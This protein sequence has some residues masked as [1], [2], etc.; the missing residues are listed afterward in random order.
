[1]FDIDQQVVCIRDD[2]NKSFGGEI[3]PKQG[4][5]LTIR[6]I[7]ADFP[8]DYTYEVGLLFYEIVNPLK[9]YFGCTTAKEISFPGSAFRP[10]KKTDISTI[11]ITKVPE[12]VN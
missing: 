7:L 2:W 10:V 12:K 9:V 4:Q 1:M 11:K 6:E 8:E 3:Y 5:I